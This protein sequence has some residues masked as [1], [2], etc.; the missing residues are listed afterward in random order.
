M[1]IV[2]DEKYS[3]HYAVTIEHSATPTDFFSAVSTAFERC[4]PDGN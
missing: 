2:V 3:E 4:K 1:K